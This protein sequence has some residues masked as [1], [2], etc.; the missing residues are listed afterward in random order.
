[1]FEEM[2]HFKKTLGDFVNT[3]LLNSVDNDL[4]TPAINA[5]QEEVED[6][7]MNTRRER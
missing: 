7:K 4:S 3:D 1:M 2:N 5:L 6:A